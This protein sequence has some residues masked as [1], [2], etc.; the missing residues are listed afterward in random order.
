MTRVLNR[1]TQGYYQAWQHVLNAIRVEV[2]NDEWDWPALDDQKAWVEATNLA[3]RH[4]EKN[5]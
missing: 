3:L 1:E 5:Q 2:G 4:W